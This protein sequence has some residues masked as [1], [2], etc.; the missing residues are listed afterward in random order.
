[1]RDVLSISRVT[2]RF[3]FLI[4]FNVSRKLI[5]ISH[6][7]CFLI[8]LYYIFFEKS[9]FIIDIKQKVKTSFYLYCE[10]PLPTFH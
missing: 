3:S 8:R 9:I 6:F 10:L 1:M 7:L 5:P 2:L 4:S